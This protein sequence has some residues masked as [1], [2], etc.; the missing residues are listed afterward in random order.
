MSAYQQP[1][2][3]DFYLGPYALQTK[4][5]GVLL[6]EH[7]LGCPSSLEPL[8]RD[9]HK[10]YCCGTLPEL[11]A[12]ADKLLTIARSVLTN[13]QLQIMTQAIEERLGNPWFSVIARL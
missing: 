7:L 8:V 1:V 12:S 9:Y 11:Q 4:P 13:H 2:E 10:H 6:D 3:L 5:R